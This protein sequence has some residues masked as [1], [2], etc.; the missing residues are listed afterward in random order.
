MASLL[1]RGGPIILPDRLLADAEVVV[2][3]ATITIHVEPEGKAKHR[4]V[5]V[6]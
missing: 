1:F 6:L 2:E 3:G 5:L 4:G